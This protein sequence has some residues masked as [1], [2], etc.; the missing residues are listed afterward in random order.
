M[1]LKKLGI[2]EIASILESTHTP[3]IIEDCELTNIEIQ[4]FNENYVLRPKSYGNTLDMFK[5][6]DAKKR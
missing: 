1:K 2:E 6:E 3:H 5:R 4:I